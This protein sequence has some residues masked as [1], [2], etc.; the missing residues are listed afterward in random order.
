[1][2]AAGGCAG[3][4][5]AAL[6][7]ANVHSAGQR[8]TIKPAAEDGPAAGTMFVT[9]IG[10]VSQATGGVTTPGFITVY[11]PGASGNARPEAEITK[12]ID[13][14]L[15]ITVD[16]SGDLWVANGLGNTVVEYSKVDLAEASPAPTVTMGLK[17][18]STP[19]GVAFDPSGHLW[20]AT[21]FG[22]L[23]SMEEFTKPELAKSGSPA[24]VFTL[25]EA[26]CR[27]AFDSSGDLWEGSGNNSS[28]NSLTEWTKAQLVRPLS[29]VTP[30][31]K[32][33]ITSS[34][35]DNPCDIAFDRAGD[36]WAANRGGGKNT[37][38]EFTK[39]QLAKSGPTAP[40]VVIS[41]SAFSLPSD[42]MFD[43]SGNLWVPNQGNSTVVEFTK[44][45]FAK[46][47]APAP[48][49]A[50]SGPATRLNFSADVAFEP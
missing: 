41:S 48:T 34:A 29:L 42:V 18:G 32:V 22:A 38:V 24:P 23:G 40:K 26:D 50:L 31:P 30:P 15:G 37:V 25:N 8:L 35:L 27:V 9:D 1:V 16:S 10:P 36:L 13:G 20:V 47:G 33:L 44:A 7:V 43:A 17:D 2:A 12:G 14:P 28:G 49:R 5:A 6:V 4:V 45:Q 19:F 21:T 46:S 11:R 3:V 39:A